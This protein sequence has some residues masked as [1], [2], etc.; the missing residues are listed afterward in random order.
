M[1]I[2][3][4]SFEPKNKQKHFSIFVLAF[5]NGSN[6]KND[7]LNIMLIS[8]SLSSNIVICQGYRDRYDIIE[9]G[10][11]KSTFMCFFHRPIFT[12]IREFAAIVLWML[13]VFNCLGRLI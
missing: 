6:H 13:A 1:Q 8:N 10:H 2:L 11:E 9:H 4:F 12:E 5:L 3:K 7:L